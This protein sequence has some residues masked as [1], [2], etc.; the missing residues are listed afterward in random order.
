[1]TEPAPPPARVELAGLAIADP[2]DRWRAL[3][4]AVDEDGELI[5]GGIRIILGIAP[6]GEGIVSWTLRGPV[7]AP[8]GRLAGL[9]TRTESGGPSAPPGGNPNGAIAVDHV[10]AMTPDFDA[11]AQALA[12]AGL[13]L[14]RVVTPTGAPDRRQGFRRLGPAI[15]E[16]VEAPEAAAP[17]FWGVTFTVAELE[18]VTEL[19]PLVGPARDAVQPGRRIA[20]VTRAAGLSTRVAFMDPEPR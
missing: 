10:V 11:T 2:P 20:A 8:A 3:G 15:V 19:A 6:P 5:A 13:E 7:A 17:R 1:L 18:S 16:I 4:F 9:A 14:R 12:D